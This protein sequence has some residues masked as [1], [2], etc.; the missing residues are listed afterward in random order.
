MGKRLVYAGLDPSL[1]LSLSIYIYIYSKWENGSEGEAASLQESKASFGFFSHTI[2]VWIFLPY[3]GLGPSLS[4]SLSRI[5]LP[6]QGLGP[7]LSLSLSLSIYIYIYIIVT[8]S[9]KTVVKK[10]QH[11]SKASFGFFSHTIDW[12]LDFRSCDIII[13]IFFFFYDTR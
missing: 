10:K 6:Y 11:H 9:G 7:S 2:G 12:M 3:Q 13:I 5:F 1:S 8:L 4:L